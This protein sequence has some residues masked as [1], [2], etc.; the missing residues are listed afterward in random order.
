MSDWMIEQP[1]GS[2]NGSQ[3]QTN[4]SKKSFSSGF[5]SAEKLGTTNFGAFFSDALQVKYLKQQLELCL[6]QACVDLTAC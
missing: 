4:G 3:V 1:I 2:N 5:F 6:L